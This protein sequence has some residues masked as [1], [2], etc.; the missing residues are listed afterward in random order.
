MDNQR[1]YYGRFQQALQG[2]RIYEKWAKKFKKNR[3]INWLL[4]L[5][6]DI[7]RMRIDYI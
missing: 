6:Q 3:V 1:S 4:T 7:W 5:I 2:R